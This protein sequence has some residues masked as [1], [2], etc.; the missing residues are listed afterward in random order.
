MSLFDQKWM[1]QNKSTTF[2]LMAKLLENRGI[3]NKEKANL[4]FGRNLNEIHDPFLLKDMKLAINRIQHAIDKNEKI[5]IFG[6][7]DVDGITATAL[8]F[9]FL[10]ELGVDIHYTLPHREKDGYGLKTYFIDQFK[11]ENVQLLVTVDCG[12]SN[13]KEITLANE[14]EIDVVVT[15]HHGLPKTLPNAW[16]IVNPHQ[17]DCDYPNKEI[18]GSTIAYKLI[19]ALAHHYWGTTKAVSYLEEQLG[20]VALGIIGDCM[21]LEGENRVMVRE[22]LKKI[23]AGKSPVIS[24]LLKAA[25]LPT[26]NVNSTTLGFQVGPRINAAGRIDHPNQAFKLLNGEI[27]Q[28]L[29]L[30]E[31]NLKRRELTKQ[32][33]DEAFDI[34]DSWSE[35]P[36][37]IAISHPDW[38]AGLLGLIASRMVEKYYRPTIAMQ[39]REDSFVGSMRSISGFNITESIREKIEPL[40]HAFG[41]HAMAGGFTLK[42][43]KIDLFKSYIYE[44]GK[45]NINEKDLEKILKIDCEALPSEISFDFYQ[46]MNLLE[47]FGNG[48]PIPTLVLK[49][50]KI[51]Q[52]KC[53]GK[54]RDHLKLRF[55]HSGQTFDGIAFRFG[56]H[57][58]KISTNQFCDVAFQL[59]V[60][61]W[62]GQKK[63]QLRIL[64]L[65]M[66]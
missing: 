51:E 41:G 45:L 13:L 53:I 52:V 44:V 47:P 27:D 62:N 55:E 29:K 23:N 31:L 40:C 10:Q 14:L 54:E 5:M 1:I 59:D 65:K 2:N 37:I 42:K 3:I 20:T 19:S 63:L 7:Y 66:K 16:A 24:A 15:D 36:P 11:K 35:I 25:G 58:D 50:L 4:F 32:Y 48:N 33:T 30:Q 64:D 38:S 21:A 57:L 49:N 46:K 22:G 28:A 12:T 26:T 17:P 6:D 56:E 61:E 8:L 9:N 34:I 43:E 39:E 60:N 18:C